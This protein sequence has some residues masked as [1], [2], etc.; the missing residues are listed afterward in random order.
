MRTTI[1]MYCDPLLVRTVPTTRRGGACSRATSSAIR[2]MLSSV[3]C[4][5]VT[6]LRISV[7][8]CRLSCVYCGVTGRTSTTRWTAT[9]TRND[10]CCRHLL[11]ALEARDERTLLALFAPNAMCV[12]AR[13][14]RRAYDRLRQPWA[15]IGLALGLEAAGPI[16]RKSASGHHQP[17]F[18][19]LD[20]SAVDLM[21]VQLSLLQGCPPPR[22]VSR[23]SGRPD[24]TGGPEAV[25]R[26][27]RRRRAL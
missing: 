23:A 21:P 20:G 26:F 11:P 18:G 1:S 13:W 15:D 27:R 14:W 10:T 9:R 12:A 4:S 25:R 22:P 3:S 2:L 24:Q 7:R 8:Q 19:M 16:D 17:G 6:F 5:T